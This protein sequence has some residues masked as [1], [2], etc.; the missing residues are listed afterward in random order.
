MTRLADRNENAIQDNKSW[1]GM[2]GDS[3]FDDYLFIG[4]FSVCF[5]MT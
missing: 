5:D 2:V 1:D 3:P 4:L